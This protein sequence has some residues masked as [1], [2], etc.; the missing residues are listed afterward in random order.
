MKMN[1]TSLRRKP[2]YEVAAGLAE[3]LGQMFGVSIPD[4]E[5]CYFTMHLLGARVNRMEQMTG[6]EEV[7]SAFGK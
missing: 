7:L 2:E 6:S 4:E 1:E 3:G 5:I